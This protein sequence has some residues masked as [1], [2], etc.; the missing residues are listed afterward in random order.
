MHRFINSLARTEF[1]K[2]VTAVE[3]DFQGF[4]SMQVYYQTMEIAAN[5]IM[6]SKKNYWLL[7][8][9]DFDDMNVFQFLTFLEKWF[10]HP[11]Y[12]QCV[13]SCNE[14]GR[15]AVLTHPVY[16]QK[17]K[18]AYKGFEFDVSLSNHVNIGL[19]SHKKVAE[20]FLNRSFMDLQVYGH[21]E[22]FSY[23]DN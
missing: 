4:G 10:R 1:K 8:K 5:L 13:K 3:V 23:I 11:S 17:L 18:Q 22:S 21:G 2:D 9:R 14:D 6:L 19:F 15:V 16:L 20:A 7:V 12:L